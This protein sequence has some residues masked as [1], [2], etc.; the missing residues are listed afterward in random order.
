MAL[1]SID[2]KTKKVNVKAFSIENPNVYAYFN[3]LPTDQRDEALQKAI[4]IGVLALMEDRLLALIG[5]TENELG[6]ELESLQQRYRIESEI[7]EKSTSKGVKEET[8]IVK[9]LNAWY[10]SK[11][12]D[13]IA[14]ETGAAP[15]NIPRNKTGDV[16]CHIDG[17]AENILGIEVKLDKSVALGDIETENVFKNQKDTAWS[18][19]IETRAN[20]GGSL[21]L[22]VFD[23]STAHQTI[24]NAC[25]GVTYIPGIGMIAIVDKARNN[26]TNLKIA[27]SLIRDVVLNFKEFKVDNQL[28]TLIIKRVIKDI[29]ESMGIKGMI[30]QNI[31]EAEKSIKH[32]VGILTQLEKNLLMLEFDQR[33]L[34]KYIEDGQLTP[35]DQLKFYEGAGLNDEFKKIQ[36]Q[37]TD[38]K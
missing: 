8:N 15:G 22:M 17:N 11:G 3:K 26:Y 37:F 9:E 2:H 20:R 7:L 13:D 32:N 16:V 27:Y 25:D 34:S 4:N 31:S 33:Y 23:E 12:W 1:I 6:A 14:F 18:Q 21:S 38:S 10:E 36:S 30:E 28:L 35:E 29:Q 5:R 24:K 19:L